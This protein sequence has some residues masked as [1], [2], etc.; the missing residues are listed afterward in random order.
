MI[1]PTEDESAKRIAA[2]ALNEY[3]YRGNTLKEWVE[4]IASE[5]LTPVRH[6]KWENLYKEMGSI[7]IDAPIL[8][9]SVCKKKS[10]FK[11][12]GSKMTEAKYCPNC[13]A[14]MDLKS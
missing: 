3:V 9:C 1:F 7:L 12:F 11:L 5:E 6:G 4:I 2:K 8:K 14:L 10:A 13:G